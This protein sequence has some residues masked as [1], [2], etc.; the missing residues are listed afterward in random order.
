MMSV[1]VISKCI[2]CGCDDLHACHSFG[3]EPCFWVVVDR[4]EGVGVCSHC[5]SE[6]YRWRKG[7]RSPAKASMWPMQG[8]GRRRGHYG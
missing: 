3:G 7:D 1:H 8:A 2:G 4:A 6:L 5:S